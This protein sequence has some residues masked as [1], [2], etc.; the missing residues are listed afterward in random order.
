MTP[1]YDDGTVT[2]YHGDCREVLS[3][4]KCSAAVTVTSPPYWNART[5]GGIHYASYEAYLEFVKE[6]LGVLLP[7]TSWV[8]WVAGYI[9]RGGRL[10]DCPGDA[11][12]TAVSLGYSWR[13]QV[14][15]VKSD[16]APQ[17]SIDLAPAHELI[18]ILA[19]SES[20]PAFWD[21][22]RV[23][24][25]QAERMGRVASERPS[26]GAQ[27][28]GGVG[29]GHERFDGKKQP[30]NVLVTQKL[31]GDDRLGHPAAF[32]PEV[33]DPWIVACSAPGGLAL[34]PFMDSGTTLRVAKDHGRKAIGIETEERYCEIAARRLSQESFDLW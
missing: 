32:P 12:R 19:T 33:A 30:P 21:A 6:V 24:R 14:P 28:G 25:R 7:R 5:Y 8:A 9:W 34:D 31:N 16:Y 11:A 17:P 22:L 23:D 20:P 18:E 26:G 15:W 10:Y 2:I 4:L 13:Q 27:R 1:Y 29:W 3:N